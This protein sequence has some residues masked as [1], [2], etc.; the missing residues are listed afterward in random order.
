MEYRLRIADKLLKISLEAL[1]GGADK[2][3]GVNDKE[4]KD[5][6]FLICRGGWPRAVNQK[7]EISL[8]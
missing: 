8:S 6:A 4:L 3:F 7:K 2:L 5:V 1:F